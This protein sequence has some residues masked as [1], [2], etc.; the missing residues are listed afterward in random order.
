VYWLAFEHYDVSYKAPA[1]WKLLY[2][3]G[4]TWKE[5]EATSAYG[6]ELDKYN[7]LTFKTIKTTGLKI[8]ASLQK[9]KLATKAAESGPQLVETRDKAYSGGIIEWKVNP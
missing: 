6:T 4:E 7:K 1:S 5:V 8:V 2:K 3:S 9:G